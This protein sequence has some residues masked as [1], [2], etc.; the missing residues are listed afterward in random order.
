M[1]SDQDLTAEARAVAA[2]V[3][4]FVKNISVRPSQD[5]PDQTALLD[6]TT[7]EGSALEVRLTT[8]G[9]HVRI[10]GGESDSQYESIEALLDDVSPGYR[11]QFAGSLASK[12]ASL[13]QAS[14]DNS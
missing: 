7:V 11:A 2:S 5:T 1:Q 14:D 8:S 10:P 13:S 9:Y 6:V 4:P 12:L 3:A